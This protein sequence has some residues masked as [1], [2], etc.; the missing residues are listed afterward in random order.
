MA[1]PCTTVKKYSS[2]VPKTCT[3]WKIKKTNRLVYSL[4]KTNLQTR[5]CVSYAS[6]TLHVSV[7]LNSI[8]CSLIQ[9]VAANNE[10]CCIYEIA[11]TADST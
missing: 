8:N 10:N 2:I 4:A 7:R 3:Q 1:L 5:Y 6:Y 9:T 11:Q